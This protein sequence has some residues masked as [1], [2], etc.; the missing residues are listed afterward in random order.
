[1][2]A[3]YEYTDRHG[4]PT[5][6]VKRIDYP[7]GTKTFHQLYPDDQ[8]GWKYPREGDPTSNPAPLYKLPEVIDGDDP[9]VVVEGEKCVETLRGIG[10]NATTNAGGAEKWT[11]E[12]SDSLRGRQVVVWGDNDEPGLRHADFVCCHIAGIV[13]SIRRVE[14]P[15]YLSTKG[16]VVDVLDEHGEDEVRRLIDE[17]TEWV[18]PAQAEPEDDNPPRKGL[19]LAADVEPKEV[20]WTWYPYIPRRHLTMIYGDGDVRKSWLAMG[21]AAGVTRGG[22]VTPWDEHERSPAKVLYFS[23]EDDVE[24]SLAP[25]A[26]GTEADQSRLYLRYGAFG[27]D[28]ETIAHVEELVKEIQP[29]LVVFDPVVAFQADVRTNEAS[30]VRSGLERLGAI[31]KR[32]DCS[33]LL[34]HHVGKDHA[35]GVDQLHLGSVDYRNASRSTLV[36]GLTDPENEAGPSM[37]AHRKHNTSPR[38]GQ[39]IEFTTE[40]PWRFRWLSVSTR[41]ID[42]LYPAGKS[43]RLHREAE[44]ANGNFLREL[45]KEGPLSVKEIMQAAKEAGLTDKQVRTAREPVC[46]K[47]RRVGGPG[48]SGHWVWELKD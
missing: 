34:V 36:V 18:A 35:R 37:F 30:E 33:I 27:W 5:R 28:E 43:T 23:G 8:G 22:K 24:Y 38:R 12:H 26:E 4:E 47:P 9:V 31:A 7:D 46:K 40:E 3:E 20:T 17:A 42:E 19:V 29:E 21:I 14:P 32:Q 10:L 39:S 44:D 1:M 2:T 13:A 11:D 45:L 15:Q 16:D 25:K 41:D 48:T 6:L